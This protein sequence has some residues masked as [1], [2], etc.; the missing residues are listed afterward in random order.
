MGVFW[1]DASCEENAESGFAY[2]GQQSGK[3]STFSAGKHWLS[4]ISEPWL[5]VIDNADDPEM[6]VSK[7]F[8]AGGSGHI[9]ITT[10]NP[11]VV[12]YAT[13]G[14]FHFGGMDPEEAVTLL[15]RSADLYQN[16]HQLN[17]ESRSAAREIASELGYLALALAYAGA[18]IR[19]KIYTLERYLYH[20]LGSRKKMLSMPPIKT[21]DDANII[22]TWEIP[23]QKIATRKSVE[24]KDAV[25]LLHLFAFLHFD[26]VP[27]L[28]FQKTWFSGMENNIHATRL[29]DASERISAWREE[30]HARL[31]RA[32]GILCGYSIIDHDPEKK[33]CSLHPV[34]HQWAK[35]RLPLGERKR[36]LTCTASVLEQCISPLEAS[37]QEFRRLLLPHVESCLRALRS[38]FPSFPK[39]VAEASQAEKFAAV[40]AEKSMWRQARSLQQDVVN[41]RTK[42]QGKWHDDTLK[43]QSS[44]GDICW[45]LFDVE[46]TVKI[47][48]HVMR[49]RWW[50]RPGPTYWLAFLKP[51][52]ISYC[53]ALSDITLS[54]WLAGRYDLSQR[55][56]ER[57][58]AG[59][60]KRLGPDDPQTLTAMF[61][62]A[63][64]Y[65]HLDKVMESRELLTVVV[66]KRKLFFGLD[67]LDTLLARH[68]LGM[69]LRCLGRL[70]AAE[71]VL[72]TVHEKAVQLLGEEHAYT[73]WSIIDVSKVVCD[74]GCAEEAALMV[75]N[76]LP[77][78]VRTLGE[79]HGQTD[80]ARLAIARAYALGGRLKESATL[81][82]EV[83][84]T[85]P[86][87]YPMWL[88]AMLGYIHVLSK[89][90]QPAELE[91]QCNKMLDHIK[92]RK[93]LSLNDPRTLE[94][95]RILLG[96]YQ[97]QH[98][99]DDI[100][101]LRKKIPGLDGPRRTETGL[102]KLIYG[103]SAYD[104]K[105]REKKSVWS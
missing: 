79:H 46:S 95:G 8:P 88:I 103:A 9:I 59:L 22:T 18:T 94:V 14:N 11:G 57:A 56:G 29:D 61:N 92:T 104:G 24:H 25:D 60:V 83:I 80:N 97:D 66:R 53:K 77:I 63:R 30:S 102:F 51:D 52:H 23:F 68:E 12:T 89:I 49:S 21:A 101:V 3:G 73:L 78:L 31:R 44:L 47:H 100:S 84:S 50:L 16:A 74:L 65:L 37:G 75:E 87:E 67:H 98:R 91:T 86:E 41:L 81:L 19:R 85:V 64:T 33:L 58:V 28:I 72:K 26:S 1:I 82:K 35:D 90:N 96:I 99:E 34:V 76:I 17:V 38:T 32:L 71:K 39:T 54:L 4:N 40:Y 6:D 15:L 93:V 43:A 5:L 70:V 62:L 13:V 36:W 55:A 105:A 42:I 10:R 7:Y 45:G 27:E 2:L 48:V 69:C 20:Y